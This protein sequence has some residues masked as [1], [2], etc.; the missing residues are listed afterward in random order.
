MKSSVDKCINKLYYVLMLK[1]WFKLPDFSIS[2]VTKVCK[3]WLTSLQLIK[4][5]RCTRDK[6][7]RCGFSHDLGGMGELK[8]DLGVCEL[9][10]QYVQRWGWN[11]KHTDTIWRWFFCAS[12]LPQSR[13]NVRVGF[14]QQNQLGTFHTDESPSRR[15]PR[16]TKPGRVSPIARVLRL[17]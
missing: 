14:P 16:K 3:T 8:R 6:P 2:E 17:F 7:L 1:L 12:K 9:P 4:A 15:P 5:E 13:P 11:N 10:S